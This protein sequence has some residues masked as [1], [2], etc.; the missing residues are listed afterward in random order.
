ML[1]P[2][3]WGVCN[4]LDLGIYEV[5]IEPQL[6]LYFEDSRTDLALD[7]LLFLLS[8]IILHYV[9]IICELHYK[10]CLALLK[11]VLCGSI[12]TSEFKNGWVYGGPPYITANGPLA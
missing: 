5:F 11:C 7:I 12:H 1:V 4:R 2:S 9:S 6:N 8:L 3:V 10:T